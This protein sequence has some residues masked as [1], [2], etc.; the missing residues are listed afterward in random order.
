[1]VHAVWSS[2]LAQVR[3]REE[4][5]V[6]TVLRVRFCVAR[7]GVLGQEGVAEVRRSGTHSENNLNVALYR[8]ITVCAGHLASMISFSPQI[9]TRREVPFLFSTQMQKQM[10]EEVKSTG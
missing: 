4:S 7:A 1:M 8:G 3:S 10:P 2:Q 5:E 9:S 6:V